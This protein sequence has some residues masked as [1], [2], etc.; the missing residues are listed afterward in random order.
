M[1]I[2]YS[3]EA[4]GILKAAGQYGVPAVISFTLETDGCLPGGET[5]AEAIEKCDAATDHY[6]SG[7]MINCA[8]PDHFRD[9]LLKGGDWRSRVCGVR[10]NASRRSHEELDNST[11]LD[12]GD[13]VEFGSDVAALREILPSLTILGGCCGT[14]IEHLSELAGSI[15]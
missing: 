1:T 4:I 9:S 13:P 14:D 10:A 3:D 11:E 8:H 2:G 15:P 7:F 6:A 5:L 12:R